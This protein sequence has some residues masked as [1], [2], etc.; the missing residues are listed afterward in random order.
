MSSAE[1]A[2]PL[3]TADARVAQRC[4]GDLALAGGR[5]GDAVI[6]DE[7]RAGLALARSW[8]GPA[9]AAARAEA[10]AVSGWVVGL[11]EQMAA[12]AAALGGYAD[13]V[14]EAHR[15][16]LALREEWTA[17]ERIRRV[18]LESANELPGAPFGSPASLAGALS[19]QQG[20]DLAEREWSQAQAQLHA[21]HAQVLAALATAGRVAAA[22]LDAAVARLPGTT[23]AG[24]RQGLEAQLPLTHAAVAWA[25]AQRQADDWAAAAGAPPADWGPAQAGLL[26]SLG[27]ALRDPLLARALLSAMGAATLERLTG[28]LAALSAPGDPGLDHTGAARARAALDALA[29]ALVTSL[30]PRA[31]ESRE[32]AMADWRTDWIRELVTSRSATEPVGSGQLT[33]LDAQALLLA[34][35]GQVAPDRRIDGQYAAALAVALV[36]AER[37][38]GPSDP[39]RRAASWGSQLAPLDLRGDPFA[40]LLDAVA[41]DPSAARSMLLA[42]CGPRKQPVIDYLLSDRLTA[43]LGRAWPTAAES[44][45]QVLL[46][47]GVGGDLDSVRVASAALDALGAT[48]ERA[49][50]DPRLAKAIADRVQPLRSAVAGLLVGRPKLWWTA[51]GSTASDYANTGLGELVGGTV[52][53]PTLI[54]RSLSR[55]TALVATLGLDG[56]DVHQPMADPTPALAR[57]I[58]GVLE[59]LAVTVASALAPPTALRDAGEDAAG[60]AYRAAQVLGLALTAAGAAQVAAG[61][62]ADAANERMRGLVGKGLDKLDVGKLVSS[63]L[64]TAATGGVGKA[65]A[66]AAVAAVNAGVDA[67]LDRLLPVDAAALM[68]AGQGPIQH[69][70]AADLRELVRRIVATSGGWDPAHSPQQWCTRTPSCV[71]FWGADGFPLRASLDTS[72]RQSLQLW[73]QQLPVGAT[74]DNAIVTGLADGAGLAAR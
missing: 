71:P 33:G 16:V 18:A 51:L 11:G 24:V 26:G 14:A 57:F 42:P 2:L 69:E 47:T 15:R 30:D 1:R 63:V 37:S 40:E 59:D 4:A 38:S 56:L 66:G 12:T 62:A 72:A 65:A 74:I 67:E 68:G 46:E 8:S 3:P 44:L 31:V 45:A 50:T 32:P 64:G 70:V 36:A 20:R 43:A 27:E 9:A 19:V 54:V 39:T 73:G 29:T 22:A 52:L 7:H 6:T 13:A 17:A 28:Q 55:F 21:R 61:E 53:A 23:A 60:A 41:G 35:A 34:S 25:D 58:D 5:A 49:Q 48:L 10:H